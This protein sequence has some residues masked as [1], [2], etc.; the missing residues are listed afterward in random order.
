MTERLS[1]AIE[2]R[3]RAGPCSPDKNCNPCLVAE[4][5]AATDEMLNKAHRKAKDEAE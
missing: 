4:I 2:A 1:R 3:A 5:L